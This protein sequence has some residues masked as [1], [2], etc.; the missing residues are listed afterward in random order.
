MPSRLLKMMI[1][2]K[3][4]SEYKVNTF[5]KELKPQKQNRYNSSRK[6]V[7]QVAKSMAG[8]F[9]AKAKDRKYFI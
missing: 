5:V 3:N 9:A 8:Y 1:Q 7:S 6:E 4:R 2:T